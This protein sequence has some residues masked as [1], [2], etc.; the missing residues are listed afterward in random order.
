[1]IASG[2]KVDGSFREPVNVPATLSVTNVV[3]ALLAA[4]L[5]GR[6]SSGPGWRE[7]RYFAMAAAAAALFSAHTM[8]LVLP[9]GDGVKMWCGR[10]NLGFAGLHGCA[11]V[12]YFAAQ[13]RRSLLPSE[14]AVFTVGLSGSL[15]AFVPGVMSSRRLFDREVSIFGLGVTYRDVLPTQLGEILMT[16]FC[17]VLVWLA[18][19]YVKRWRQGEPAAGAHAIALIVLGAC[20]VNDAVASSGL[21]AMPYLT[22]V[23]FMFVVLAVGTSVTARFVSNARA[24]DESTMRLA[25]TQREL[26]VRERLAAIG[27]LS[28]VVAHEVRNPLAV[29]FNAVAGLKRMSLDPNANVLLSIVEEEAERLKRLVEELLEFARP[30]DAAFEPVELGPLL[31]RAVDAAVQST[32]KTEPIDVRVE[33]DVGTVVC[34]PQLLRQAIVNLVTNAL[35]A[36]GRASAV[37]VLVGTEGDR[38]L[39]I[40]VMDDG[41]G[42]PDAIAERIFMPFFTTRP[43][44]TGLGLPIVR[45]AADAHGGTVT[46]ERSPGGGATF[47]LRLPIRSLSSAVWRAAAPQEERPGT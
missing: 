13:A 3:V 20:G 24:L 30:R 22:D 23:G 8:W 16:F 18:L 47:V 5:T 28:A 41:D 38:T 34:D 39:R 32:S 2:A 31:R 7:L 44:G 43:T 40:A 1:M 33:E 46:H 4:I 21:S 45:R 9:V 17:A 26:V 35:L 12:L 37:R 29:V 10:M 11:W 14:R 27:E 6:I 36:P 42:I 19:A 15:L 25:E